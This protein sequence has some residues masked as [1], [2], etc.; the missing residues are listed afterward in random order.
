MASGSVT[1]WT[2]GSCQTVASWL[3]RRRSNREEGERSEAVSGFDWVRRRPRVCPVNISS[4][5]LSAGRLST[6]S[7]G[8]HLKIVCSDSSIFGRHGEEEERTR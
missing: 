4:D 7:L 6:V 2:A 1:D 5:T 8:S 3:K